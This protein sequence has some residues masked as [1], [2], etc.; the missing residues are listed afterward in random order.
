[1]YNKILTKAVALIPLTALLI[2]PVQTMAGSNHTYAS[3][4]KI[5][6]A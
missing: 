4:N 2:N 6:A 1:M 3:A 5:V